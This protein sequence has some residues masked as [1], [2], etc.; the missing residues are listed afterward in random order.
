M[1]LL[2][3]M[4]CCSSLAVASAQTADNAPASAASQ[5]RSITDRTV[6]WPTWQQWR[7]VLL[8]E[9]Y[10]TRVVLLGT[11]LLGVAAGV[12]GNFTLLRT[13]LM[14]QRAEPRH[15]SQAWGWRSC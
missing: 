8:L 15:A 3:A 9:D 4:L 5:Q 6:D 12:V 1:L 2:A 10:N 13:R 7:R 14:G 11:T